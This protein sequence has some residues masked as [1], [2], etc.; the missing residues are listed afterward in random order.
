MHG[1]KIPYHVVGI[2]LV[3]WSPAVCGQDTA[4]ALPEA[5]IDRLV[6][7][8]WY[9]IDVDREGCNERFQGDF[10]KAND[11]WLVLRR[12][13]ESRNDVGVPSASNNSFLKSKQFSKVSI[14]V[15]TEYLWIPREAATVA[16]RTRAAKSQP[17]AEIDGES[18]ASGARCAVV[19]PADQKTVEHKGSLVEMTDE[20]IILSQERRVYTKRAVPLLG[21]LPLIGAAFRNVTGHSETVRDEIPWASVL[22][23]RVNETAG[24]QAPDAND[25]SGDERQALGGS[26]P[27]P[28]SMRR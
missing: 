4:A 1:C 27:R 8:D 2:I 22:C 23:V 11:R 28:G 21:E 18:P 20:T 26:T 3:L 17:I 19:L 14:G 12:I 16:G 13:S 24:D 9:T 5:S 15:Q 10:V 25:P 6:V 7:G